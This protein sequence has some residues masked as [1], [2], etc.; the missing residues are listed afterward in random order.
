[1][2]YSSDR[3]HDDLRRRAREFCDREIVPHVRD[4]DRESRFPEEMVPK[5]AAEGFL[6]LC[7]PES[8]GGGGQDYLAL[9][10]L[11]EELERADTA[12]RVLLSV[13][14]G[15]N[16]LALLQW[17]TDEQKQRYLQPQARGQ[18]LAAFGLTEPE[19]GSDVAA[20]K[21]SARREGKSY[22]LNGDKSW[23]GFA[24]TADHFLIFARSGPGPGSSGLSAFIVERGTPGLKTSRIEHKLGGRAGN[25][26]RILLHD[27]A[28][29]EENRLGGEGDGFRI[30]MGALDNGRYTVAAGAVGLIEACLDASSRFARG[31]L[32]FGKAI[33]RHQLVQQKI[34]EMV[35]GRDI[36]RLL[37]HK[38]GWLKNQGRRS[39][40]EVSL[41][42]WINCRNAFAAADAAV[43]IHGSRGYSDEFPVERYLRNSRGA[44]IYE[45]T[46]EIHQVLQAEYALGYREDKPLKRELPKFGG[47]G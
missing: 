28:V 26:G 43:Q 20:L 31:R 24:D 29:A 5:L 4:W 9:G 13:H 8:E 27:V 39:T 6:G 22:I 2:D 36:G 10:L 42:K 33:G 37:W 40:R 45:G 19:A 14:L 3:Q 38:V 17:G 23:I 11:C 30:A 21:C 16:S 1:M 47:A 15:L 41:A 46:E 12:F 18:K 32:A 7:I 25:T 34:A 35:A 44:R